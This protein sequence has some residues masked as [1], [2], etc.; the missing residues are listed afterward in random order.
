[1]TNSLFRQGRRI[2][3][4]CAAAWTASAA[5][6][7]KLGAQVLGSWPTGSM[8]GDF[9]SKTG[10]GVGVF[11]DW[12]LGAG[13]THL[14]V[15][16]DGIWYPSDSKEVVVTNQASVS[17]PTDTNVKCRSHAVTAQLLVYP[18]R[19]SEGFYYKVGL[20]GANY[21]TRNETSGQPTVLTETGVKLNCLA[22]VGY[23][24]NEHWGVLAQYSFINASGRTL[25][26][27]QTGVNF[28]F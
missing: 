10:Y 17:V 19:A 24:F 1:M 20:G 8:R 12:E 2:L 22:G 23:D 4:C 28:K 13:A 26:S 5:D 9:T 6:M 21:L 15:G 7:P 27:A 25:G 18:N 3:F 16:W 11:A 14:R